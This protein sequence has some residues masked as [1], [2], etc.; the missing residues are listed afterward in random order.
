[1]ND[2]MAVLFFL[3]LVLLN[4][5]FFPHK[6]HVYLLGFHFIFKGNVNEWG[7]PFF[8]CPKILLFIKSLYAQ[9]IFFSSIV[10]WEMFSSLIC[11]LFNVLFMCS[12]GGIKKNTLWNSY[13]RGKCKWLIIMFHLFFSGC[14]EAGFIDLRKHFTLQP[15]SSW[16][17]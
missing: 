10:F 5:F 2:F 14:L 16:R 3:F 13:L 17:G 7:T 15:E 6:M 11:G 1:M 9:N 12:F 4:L 8:S